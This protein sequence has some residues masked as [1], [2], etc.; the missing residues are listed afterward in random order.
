MP[1]VKRYCR[2]LTRVLRNLHSPQALLGFPQYTM[3]NYGSRNCRAEIGY[4]DSTRRGRGPLLGVAWRY[5]LQLN[6]GLSVNEELFRG[7][8][9]G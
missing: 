2:I 1:E 8:R 6:G 5:L 7:L 9:A 3:V 4:V